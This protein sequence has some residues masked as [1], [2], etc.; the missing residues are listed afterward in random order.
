MAQK[1]DY[2]TIFTNLGST[3]IWNG[4]TYNGNVNAYI[5]TGVEG[6]ALYGQYWSATEYNDNDA[7]YFQSTSWSYFSKSQKYRV[8]PV[9]GF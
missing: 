2:E 7:R 3:T 8:R 4:T 9:L 1:S 6:A 5:T